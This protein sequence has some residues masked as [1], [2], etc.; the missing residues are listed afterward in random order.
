MENDLLSD[1]LD[2]FLRDVYDH[3][4]QII[5]TVESYRDIMSGMLEIYLANVSNRMN[6]VMKVLTIISTIFIPLNFIAGV[7]GMNFHHMPELHWAY[8]YPMALGLMSFVA[9]IL[10]ILFRIKKWI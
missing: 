2:P 5:D 10:L 8:G 9:L 3:T 7:Y 6:E 4:V 1:G